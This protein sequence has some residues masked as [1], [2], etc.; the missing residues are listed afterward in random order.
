MNAL[1]GAASD[2]NRARRVLAGTDSHSI[3]LLETV[4]Y[5]VRTNTPGCSAVTGMRC[6]AMRAVITVANGGEF[7]DRN[8]LGT[9]GG[10]TSGASGARS[11]WVRAWATRRFG[12]ADGGGEK[13]WGCGT[14]PVRPTRGASRLS[15][16]GFTA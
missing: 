9:I 6:A 7:S 2:V 10:P 3:I 4:Q 14:K 12:F 1:R 5:V 13:R 8:G 15:A 16:L 11:R